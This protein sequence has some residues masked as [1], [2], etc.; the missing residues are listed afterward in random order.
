MSDINQ[1]NDAPFDKK[2]YK[3]EDKRDDTVQEHPHAEQVMP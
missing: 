2:E 3:G 1:G